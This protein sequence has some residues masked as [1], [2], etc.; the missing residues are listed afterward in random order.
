MSFD[1][2]MSNLR[3]DIK[4]NFCS[5]RS[6]QVQSTYISVDWRLASQAIADNSTR[7]ASPTDTQF[8]NALCNRYIS[9]TLFLRGSYGNLF[10]V[11]QM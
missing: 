5:D 4:I 10:V 8:N 2:V 6:K 11:H 1:E 3:A 7:G 9:S